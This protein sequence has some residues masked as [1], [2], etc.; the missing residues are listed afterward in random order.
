[1]AFL[2]RGRGYTLFLTPTEAA[3]RLAGSVLR[4]RLVGA[5]PNPKVEGRDPLP[6]RSHYFRGNDPKQW[7]TNI[8]HYARVRYSNVYPGVDLVYHGRQDRLEYD[9]ALAPGA[10][11]SRIRVAF[12]GADAMRLDPDGALVIGVGGGEVE[13]PAPE[14]YQDLGG[15]RRAVPVKYVVTGPREVGF[16]LGD[17]DRSRPLLIDPVLTYSTYLGGS[18]EDRA[19]SIKVDASGYVYVAG[20][21]S[22][23][24]FP[25]PSSQAKPAG[26]DAFVTKLNPE[27]TALVFSTYLGSGRDSSA[28]DDS[29]LSIAVDASGSACITG[30]ALSGFPTVNAA[31]PSFGGGV[32]DAFVARLDAT[33]S[34]IYSTYLG[35]MGVDDG[36]GI[37]L[38]GQGNA[39][40]VGSTYSTNFPL[41]NPFQSAKKNPRTDLFTGFVAKLD[42]AGSIIYSTYLGGGVEDIATAVAVDGDGNAYLTGYTSSPDFPVTNSFQP[43]FRGWDDAFVAKLDPAGTTLLYSTYLGGSSADIATAI[44]VDGLGNAHVAGYTNSADFP[45]ANA[46]QANLAG[47]SDAFVAV[48]DSGGST[49]TLSTLLGGRGVEFGNAVALDAQ[50]NTYVA[51]GTVSRDFPIKNPLQVVRLG[52]GDAFVAKVSGSGELLYSSYLG[53]TQGD[54]AGA[55]AVDGSGAAYV[56]GV[57]YSADFP[58][59]NALQPT[60]KGG[61]LDAFVAKVMDGF[62]G[63]TIEEVVWTEIVNAAATG[64]SLQKTSGCEGCPDAGGVSRQKIIGGDAYVEFTSSE[65]NTLRFIG[66][67]NGSTSTSPYEI[68]YA[69]GLGER[70]SVYENGVYRAETSFVPG[71]RLRIEVGGGTVTY[72]KNGALLYRSTVPPEYPLVLD[73]SLFN[74]G[75]TVTDAVIAGRLDSGSPTPQPTPF[76]G[77]PFAVPGVIQAEDFDRGGEGVAYHDNVPGNAGGLYRPQ[78][79]VD[80][81]SP[82]TDG[83]VVNNFETGEWL[84]YTI[85]VSQAGVYRLETLA[86]SEF[87]G[88]RWHMEI[89]GV[90]VTGPVTVPNT[91]SWRTFEWVGVGGVSLTAGRHVLRI[92]AEREYFNLDALR[93]VP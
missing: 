10:D 48:L 30:T 62:S 12:G 71:D 29:A 47:E 49:L 23:L 61:G 33:G 7:R 52:G 58:T 51:G 85:D 17:H 1:V 56:A 75:G 78:E 65:A 70:A 92:Q 89:D 25:T 38:D 24:D 73:A 82:Y 60:Y 16:D 19:N 5:D 21:T 3:L 80:I 4:M 9:L 41:V 84:A 54:N 63:I 27:G 8:P 88:S 39:S 69:I 72:Y 14:A 31:Q 79:D 74:L 46:F 13:Q 42:A 50:G 53:G 2:S 90:D 32:S 93:I 36:H 45:T 6:G 28:R 81:I 43:T 64:R 55:V 66:L 91:G 37:A 83:Y 18:G 87:E 35:G 59:V 40:V 20:S 68:D 77:Q 22:S 76:S 15:M 11:P 57:T 26:T 67:S 44:A 86:S 34:L